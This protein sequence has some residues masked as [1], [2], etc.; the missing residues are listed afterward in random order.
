MKKYLSFFIIIFTF[1]FVFTVSAATPLPNALGSIKTPQDLIG[2]IINS[3]LGIVGSITLLMFVYG[4]LT[5]MTSSG[6][7]EKIKKGRDIIL[8]SA[9]GL[10]IIFTSYALVALIIK[11]VK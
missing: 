11:S 8:W 1:F 2:K 5:W 9:I 3:A 7:S 4:G 6:S 10:A